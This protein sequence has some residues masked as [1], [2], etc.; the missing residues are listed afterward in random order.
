MP[1]PNRVQRLALW[2]ADP[3]CKLCGVVTEDPMEVCKRFNVA[4][5]AIYSGVIPPDVLATVATLDHVRV[6]GKTESVRLACMRCNQN[7]EDGPGFNPR[8]YPRHVADPVR[9]MSARR[10][11]FFDMNFWTLVSMGLL[12][13][14]AFKRG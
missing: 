5:A 10:T 8:V 2:K 14:M 9:W 7:R 3:K 6:N 4:P 1:S 12:A 11:S 13:V